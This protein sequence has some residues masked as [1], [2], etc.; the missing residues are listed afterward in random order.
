M[1]EN[2]TWPKRETFYSFKKFMNDAVCKLFS[3]GRWNE[4]NTSAFLTVKYHNS[5]NLVFQHF[6]VKEKV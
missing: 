1:D 5:E 4:L 3:S 6:L 2:S